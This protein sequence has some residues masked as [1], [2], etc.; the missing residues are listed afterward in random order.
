MRTI[1]FK[2][3]MDAEAAK[4]GKHIQVKLNV[5]MD[6]VSRETLETL[7]CSAQ[8]VRWQ[9][10]IRARWGE[11]IPERVEF[12]VPLF[13][14]ARRTTTTVRDMSIGEAL[15]KVKALTR[16]DQLKNLV[17]MYDAIGQ[18]PPQSILDELNE[19]LMETV[20]QRILDL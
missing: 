8:V 20:D 1:T 6:K 3:A 13:G 11:A 12:G 5:D 19:L 10:E 17:R 4:A 2:V 18:A 15:E 7:A 16:T 9:A 14:T